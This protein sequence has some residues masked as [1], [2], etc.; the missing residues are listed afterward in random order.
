MTRRF[1]QKA[2]SVAL[3]LAIVGSVTQGVSAVAGLFGSSDAHAASWLLE[4]DGN[5]SL[6]DGVLSLSGDAI[7]SA[8]YLNVP[9]NYADLGLANGFRVFAAPSVLAVPNADSAAVSCAPITNVSIADSS[10]EILAANTSRVEYCIFVDPANTVALH[11]D[12]FGSATAAGT[13]ETTDPKFPDGIFSTI[14]DNMDDGR[15]YKYAITGRSASGTAAITGF[16][17]TAV[18]FR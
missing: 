18:S 8:S 2:I 3:A 1:K 14:C 12:L 10:E 11:I 17:C 7:G 4:N 5:T 15:I 6:S 13:A 9:S 16:E